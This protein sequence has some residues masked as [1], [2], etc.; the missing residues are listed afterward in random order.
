M[1]V[2]LIVSSVVPQEN[3]RK[4]LTLKEAEVVALSTLKEVMEEKVLMSFDALL[5]QCS[6]NWICPVGGT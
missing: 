1:A 3:Y 5:C 4:D 2:T 6:C